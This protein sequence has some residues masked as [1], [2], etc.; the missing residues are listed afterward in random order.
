M[1]VRRNFSGGEKYF[2]GTKFEIDGMV[3]NEDVENKP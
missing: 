1:G 2:R 3:T